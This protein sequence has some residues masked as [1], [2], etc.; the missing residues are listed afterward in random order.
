MEA[1]INPTAAQG[2]GQA[3]Q[4][5]ESGRPSFPPQAVDCLLAGLR[6]KPGMGVA[7]VGA[8]TGKLTR[9]L[10]ERG[11]A[12]TAVE[13]VQGMRRVFAQL[14][15][16]VTLLEGMAES[17]PLADAS[18]DAVVAAQAFH[19]FKGPQALK[20]FSRVLKPG[21]GLGLVWNVRDES[22]DWVA[23]LG[24]LVGAHQGLAP[25]Y[26][27]MAWKGAFAEAR[28]FTPL[29]QQSF[30]Y[31]Q[32]GTPSGILDRVRSTSF[33]A[34]LPQAARQAVLDQ[35][36]ALLARHPQTRG[37]RELPVPYRTEVY[38]CAAQGRG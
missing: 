22:V 14:L 18:L 24:R 4:A 36:A 21:A 7:D 9:L 28:L 3:G 12:V 2:F 23:E 29:R 16:Q 31:T 34:V 13:P 5:Y 33:I 35:V 32:P 19:W 8:G 27:S 38:W 30:A 25:R 15:P 26:G 6:L 1:G 20:E 11:L 17:L 37:R 10:V